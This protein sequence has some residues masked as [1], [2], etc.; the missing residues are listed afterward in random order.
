V[1]SPF[2][3]LSFAV[4]TLIIPVGRNIKWNLR[5]IGECG[6]GLSAIGGAGSFFNGA[7][8]SKLLYLEKVLYSL[9]QAVTADYG[10]DT[11][12]TISARA[13]ISRMKAAMIWPSYSTDTSPDRCTSLWRMM[14]DPEAIVTNLNGVGWS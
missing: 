5:A 2:N 12:S 1:V 14:I 13:S 10:F 6:M 8:K 7:T 9:A 4:V 3:R 11:A